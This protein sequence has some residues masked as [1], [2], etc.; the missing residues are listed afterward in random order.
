MSRARAG[1]SLAFLIVATASL[2]TALPAPVAVAAQHKS[3][4]AAYGVDTG[5][6]QALPNKWLL[7]DVSGV[8]VDRHD[9]IW[10]LN[11]P[12]SLR[13]TETQAG[14]NPPTAKCCV[15]PPPVL[16]FDTAG[17][18]LRSWGGAQIEGWFDSEHGIFVD[19]EDHV[20]ILGAGGHDG[21]LIKFT[22]EG[23][24]LLRIGRKGDY[25][26]PDD[27]TMLGAPTD[28]YVD[29]K[30]REV[31]VSDGY[32]NHRVIVFDA[33]TGAFKRQWTAFG[34]PVD[35]AYATARENPA[36][37]QQGH[38]PAHFTTVH[39][40][41]MIGDELHVCDRAN[42]RIQVFTPA[43]AYL[44]EI[45]FNRGMAGAIGA[46]WDAAPVPGHPDEIMALDGSNSEFAVL[47]RRSG[48][49]L[50][51]YQAKGRYAGQMHWPH[52][53]A[54]DRQGRVYVAEVGGSFRVQRFAPV[55]RPSR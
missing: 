30:R 42:D 21:Q 38:D 22:A 26:A 34:K 14:N 25:V 32:R 35:P 53:I 4:P 11:R 24:P 13:P 27:P 37:S 40:V 50:A 7:G 41:T 48:A 19:D 5:W 15:A 17:K 16:E 31:F 18:L 8:S 45:H 44:R 28:I 3:S 2:L 6:P 43:G 9:H 49:V 51:S 54:I 12:G 52:Q 1:L 47:D 20:W 23:K 55:G 46:T 33:Q 10:V 39:C 29:T 36:Y